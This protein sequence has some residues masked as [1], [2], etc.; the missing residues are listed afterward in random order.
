M[1]GL[2]EAVKI[3]DDE[4]SKIKNEFCMVKNKLEEEIN[5]SKHLKES[6]KL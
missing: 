5:D 2:Q 6:L 3:R 1:S 4:L